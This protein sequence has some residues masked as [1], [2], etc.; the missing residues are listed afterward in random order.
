MTD[1][2]A[3]LQRTLEKALERARTTD[4]REL[5]AHI[6]EEGRRLVFLLNGLIRT[7]R[8]YSVDNQAFEA[9]ASELASTLAGL[10]RLLGTVHLICVED[11][12]Y[13]NEV[14]L[15]VRSTEQ[16][17]ADGFIAELGRH[18][19]GGLRIHSAVDSAGLRRLAE[20]LSAAAAAGHPRA[21]LQEQLARIGDFELEGRYRFR[22]GGEAEQATEQ[23]RVD[24]LRRGAHVVH[25]VLAN[26]AAGRAPNPLPVRRVVIDLVR[27]LD[28][29]TVPWAVAGQRR[30]PV[31]ERHVL[32]VCNLAILLGRALGM[33]DAVLS[34]LGVAAMLHDV[35]YSSV[36][37]FTGHAAAGLRL[38]LKQR[39][40]HEAKIRRALA[41][42]EH[43]QPA[44]A[45][46]P[47]SELP[48]PSLFSRVL[49]IVDDYEA[50]T[51]A[52]PA[53][54]P[55]LSPARALAGMWAAAGGEY[56][57]DLLA[58]FAQV[59]GLYP[60]GTLLELS[61]GRW[62]VSV[63]GG[64]DAARFSW[65]VVRVVREA[66]GTPADASGELDL[67]ELSSQLAPS[68]VLDPS[69][70]DTGAGRT[71]GA[72]SDA[73]AAAVPSD[74]SAPGQVPSAPREEAAPPAAAPSP[75]AAP[76]A[77]STR[78]ISGTLPATGGKLYE[79][80]LAY[81][82]RDLFRSRRTGRLRL[83]HGAERRTILLHEGRAVGAFSDASEPPHGEGH[84][85][86]TPR[87][88]GALAPRQVVR[89]ALAWGG[90][91]YCFEE[92][93]APPPQRSL[94]A[95]L[96]IRELLLEAV[97]AIRD[98]HLVRHLLGDPDRR[99]QLPLDLP[100]RGVGIQ[101]TAAERLILTSIHERAT[102]RTSLETL[103][104]PTAEAEQALLALVFAGLV[105]QL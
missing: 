17:V 7:C 54:R 44:V 1:Q 23:D 37:D 81:L 87:A 55:P 70:E 101:L 85:G 31:L 4:D 36:P 100:R 24:A 56:D 89:E 21:A 12:L 8:L 94:G 82:L 61:D 26:L 25:E 33:S 63:S 60:P 51:S 98:P 50:L 77:E 71:V 6:R 92:G 102:V 20:A 90:G 14:R 15:R 29:G 3:T 78:H 75:S 68:R 41:V 53:G 72:A 64:R 80:V 10:L 11:Q 95:E 46:E 13:V 65:P 32:T 19:V 76:E 96:P 74:P 79:G 45:A 99:L 84:P 5:A 18:D 22:V 42:I 103:A 34:D 38:V 40:F 48:R 49:H 97:R 86:V 73:V 30:M 91:D 59:L 88:A 9:P 43:H 47:A 83:S 66:N 2:A 52:R 39:G 16:P 27:G 104:L 93:P 35:G 105:D 69:G 58:L 57:A 28:Q 67:F 62:A